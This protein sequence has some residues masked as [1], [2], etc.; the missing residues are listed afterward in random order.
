MKSSP[1]SRFTVI[2]SYLAGRVS[3]ASCIG[4][5][6]CLLLLAGL[7]W[8]CQEVW[9]KD[10]FRL[11]TALLLGLHQRANPFLDRL[12][13]SVTQFGNPAFVVVLVLVSL[14]GLLWQQKRLEA[15]MFAIACL[16]A[17]VLNQG[18][19][20]AFARPRP[21]LWHPLV[22]ETSYS[23]PSGHALGSLV[24]Y[25]FL[26]YLLVRFY[27]RTALLTYSTAVIVIGLI[28]LSRLYLG[29]HY[30]TDIMAGYIVGLLWLSIC[31]AMLKHYGDQSVQAAIAETKCPAD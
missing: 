26:A 6:L 16:G 18:M 23:F 14:T 8:L 4:F 20:L 15:G 21:T 2:R 12:M 29:V 5:G 3:A 27:P 22:Q 7:S 31:V 30:P 10:S 25:G 17:L 1:K 9:E 11:D 19:K 13:L 24:L 28:G